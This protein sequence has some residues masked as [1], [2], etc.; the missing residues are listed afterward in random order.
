MNAPSR[1]PASILR[2]PPGK[3]GLYAPWPLVGVTALLVALI[4]F[5]PVLVSNGHQP[6]PGILTQAELVVD[7]S[8][9]NDTFHFYV[10]A[11]GEEIRYAQIDVGV[12]SGFSWIGI[13]AVPWST[14]NWT[15][16]YNQTNVLSEIIASTENPVALDIFA[17]Y[18]Y[19]AGNTWYVGEL[20]FY[21][22]GLPGSESLDW[23]TWTSG[24]TVTSPQ[25]VASDL[26]FP[27]PLFDAGSGGGP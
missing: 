9:G 27:I 8:P 26:P 22:G 2:R 5:T 14:L 13:N 15:T 23:A 20:A 11:L 19:S 3:L 6:G 1:I 16:W 12:A 17:N 4:V 24:I 21:V 10:W 25:S 7:R 18:V